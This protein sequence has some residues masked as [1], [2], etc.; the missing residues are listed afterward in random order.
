MLLRACARAYARCPL[1]VCD[2]SPGSACSA[3]S[4]SA[5]GLTCSR[6]SRSCWRPFAPDRTPTHRPVW[7]GYSANAE[8]STGSFSA[9]QAS[10]CSACPANSASSAGS[11]TCACNSGYSGSGSGSSLACASTSC[12][13]ALTRARPPARPTDP[14]LAADVSGV[15]ARV[16][17]ITVCPQNTFSLAGST[18]CSACPS[19]ST[20]SAGSATCQCNAGYETAGSGPSLQCTGAHIVFVHTRASALLAVPDQSCA[21]SLSLSLFL[22]LLKQPA[23]PAPSAPAACPA[24]VMLRTRTR[25]VRPAYA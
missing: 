11:A 1:L 15:C 12:L 22:N 24:P 2:P 20:S 9:A 6:T 19:E 4:A 25:A 10:S 23:P 13:S 8:C 14:G 17:H 21:L 7:L 16:A 3:G 5:L 18:A